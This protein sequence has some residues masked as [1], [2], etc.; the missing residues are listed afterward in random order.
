MWK[1]SD[2][3]I[4]RLLKAELL[5]YPIF[6][7]KTS[8]DNIAENLIKDFELYANDEASNF[9]GSRELSDE[10][11]F[12]ELCDFVYSVYGKIDEYDV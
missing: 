8:M 3:K 7:I 1:T 11:Y 5:T 4:K 9:L 2:D 10:E 6:T 12:S